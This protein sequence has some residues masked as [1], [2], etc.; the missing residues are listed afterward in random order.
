MGI[1]LCSHN[2]AGFIQFIVG[3]SYDVCG[4][5][6]EI[7]L[8]SPLPSLP[9]NA[10]PA[11]AKRVQQPATTN[12]DFS[13]G[14]GEEGEE[15]EKAV[16]SGDE[17]SEI[18]NGASRLIRVWADHLMQNRQKWKMESSKKGTYIDVDSSG[19]RV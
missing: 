13:D 11:T 15:E 2:Y 17:S 12:G 7:V 9:G 6:L 14:G 5:M 19:S 16:E 10:S 4:D 18:C 1:I 8:S 3:P